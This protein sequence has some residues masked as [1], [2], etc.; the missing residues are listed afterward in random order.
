MKVLMTT[1]TVGGV[2][3]YALQLAHALS[4]YG[5]EVALASMGPEPSDRQRQQ[6]RE[7]PRLR[8]FESAYR[9]EWMDEPWDDVAAAGEWLLDLEQHVRPAGR[10]GIAASPLRVQVAVSIADVQHTALAVEREIDGQNVRTR[11]HEPAVVPVQINGSA[12]VA[13]GEVIMH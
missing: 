4:N 13:G 9:L 3:T 12:S 10:G 5:V 7:V 2:W 1:D 6:A 11:R 8:L